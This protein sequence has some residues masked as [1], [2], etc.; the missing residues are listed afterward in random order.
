MNTGEKTHTHTQ[1][2]KIKRERERKRVTLT[3]VHD[4]LGI[5]KD[6]VGVEI[7]SGVKPK[8]KLLLSITFSLCEH[9]G[10]EDIRVST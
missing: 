9:I 5:P 1:G 3:R 2:L 7:L 6:G 8:I 4:G 10:V